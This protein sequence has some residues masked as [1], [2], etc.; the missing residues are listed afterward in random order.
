MRQKI[1]FCEVTLNEPF[2]F[3]SGEKG[4]KVGPN[5]YSCEHEM[6]NYYQ[7]YVNR[8]V[9]FSDLGTGDRFTVPS[10]FLPTAKYMKLHPAIMDGSG[11]P[12]GSVCLDGVCA[13]GV[14][15]WGKT[16]PE[17]EIVK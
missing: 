10:H 11:Q 12:A 4:V 2:E 1:K 3:S 9:R 13:G 14:N 16:N 17:V 6:G 5:K 7:V 8:S 15:N